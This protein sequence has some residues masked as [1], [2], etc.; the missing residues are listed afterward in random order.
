M[1][2]HSGEISSL[3]QVTEGNEEDSEQLELEEGFFE[4]EDILAPLQGY[5][6]LRV[7]S[8]IQGIRIRR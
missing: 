7:Q 3:P 4:V 6:E 5:F 2:F 8:K 1:G